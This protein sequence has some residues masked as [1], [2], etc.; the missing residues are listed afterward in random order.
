VTATATSVGDAPF[1]A[2][3]VADAD[4]NPDNDSTVANL[5]IVE[6]VDLSVNTLPATQ[7]GLNRS[8]TIRAGM[9]NRSALNATGIELSISLGQGLRADS[10]SWSLG[11]CTVAAQRIDCETDNFAAQGSATVDFAITGTATGAQTYTV[12]MTS[13]EVDANTAD[14]SRN[15]TVTVNAA[16]SDASSGGGGGGSASPLFLWLLT[17]AAIRPTPRRRY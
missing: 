12:S 13:A 3:V 9:D 10:A 8:T 6:P 7:V 11:S 1:S 17:F 16:T 2:S 4:D 14:N 5:T 15:G